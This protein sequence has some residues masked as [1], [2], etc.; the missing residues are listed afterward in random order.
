[1][2]LIF[3]F[4]EYETSELEKAL[5]AADTL[6]EIFGEHCIDTEL[7]S[8]IHAELVNRSGC[9]EEIITESH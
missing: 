3:E 8:A 9:S 7:Y 1:M 2:N 6:Y 4:D 5:E